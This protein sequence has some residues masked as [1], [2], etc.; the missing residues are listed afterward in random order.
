[1]FAENFHFSY[2]NLTDSS[3]KL[4]QFQVCFFFRCWTFEIKFLFFIILNLVEIKMI[5]W[6]KSESIKYML[7]VRYIIEVNRFLTEK[8]L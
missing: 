8:K 7:L 3:K 1:M 5:T 2:F 4:L 6:N